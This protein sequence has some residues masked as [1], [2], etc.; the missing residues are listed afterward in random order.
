MRCTRGLKHLSHLLKSYHVIMHQGKELEQTVTGS[1]A[2]PTQL[3]DVPHPDVPHPGA[4]GVT[5]VHLQASR[6]S[7]SAQQKSTRWWEL[8]LVNLQ[9]WRSV[10]NEALQQTAQGEELV[11]MPVKRSLLIVCPNPSIPKCSQSHRKIDLQRDCC[12]LVF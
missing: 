6:L 11:Y 4:A 7:C 12:I 3:I 8:T 2:R 1:Y 10:S 5:E 9:P